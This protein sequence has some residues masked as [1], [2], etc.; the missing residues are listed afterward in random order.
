[1]D[2]TVSALTRPED[3]PGSDSECLKDMVGKATAK[4]P[5]PKRR[6]LGCESRAGCLGS[7]S[8]GRVLDPQAWLAR[9]A[10]GPE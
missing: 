9:Q 10:P 5:L 8:R 1:M 6:L 2:S 3:P 7:A 4:P